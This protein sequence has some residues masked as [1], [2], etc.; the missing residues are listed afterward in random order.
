SEAQAAGQLGSV[1]QNLASSFSTM[2]R[3]SATSVPILLTME[4]SMRRMSGTLGGAAGA[5]LIGGVLALGAAFASIEG[6]KSI[7]SAAIEF[8]KIQ[9]ALRAATGSV[10]AAR[11]EFN[12]IVGV[13]QQL[14]IELEASG[15]AYA[16]LAA[17]AR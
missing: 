16:K 10:E 5:G 11:E 3:A 17:S 15:V 4:E 6:V 13:S 2:S 12:F 14:G 1:L 9:G 7:A 8:Q